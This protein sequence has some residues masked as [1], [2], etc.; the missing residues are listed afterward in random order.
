MKSESGP[1][2]HWYLNVCIFHENRNPKHRRN[3]YHKTLCL[4]FNY[5]D[6]FFSLLSFQYNYPFVNLLKSSQYFRAC[7]NFYWLCNYFIICW[8]P[9]FTTEYEE[10]DVFSIIFAHFQVVPQ[11][12]TKTNLA[13]STNL[14]AF[15]GGSLPNV[16]KQ[17][18]KHQTSNN[19]KVQTTNEMTNLNASNKKVLSPIIFSDD[20]H[21]S[22][23]YVA[24]SM[25]AK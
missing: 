23:I 2:V 5:I 7:L 15:K 20:I 12:K 11:T 16:S 18:R 1:A 25:F 3:R 4:P 17:N 6:V 10:N 9:N 22:S 19:N 8:Y 21:N 14:G 13:P 24:H